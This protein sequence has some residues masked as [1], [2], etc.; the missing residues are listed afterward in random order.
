MAFALVVMCAA[1]LSGLWLHLR[2]QP[3]RQAIPVRAKRR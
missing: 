3:Q 1:T 2:A